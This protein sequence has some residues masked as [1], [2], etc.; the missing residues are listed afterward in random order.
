LACLREHDEELVQRITRAAPAA[1]SVV[2]LATLLLACVQLFLL[3]FNAEPSLYA[4]A[5]LGG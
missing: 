1:L 4:R 2:I 3:G 5:A